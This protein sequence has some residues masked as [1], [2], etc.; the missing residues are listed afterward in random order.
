VAGEDRSDQGIRGDATLKETLRLTTDTRGQN[1]Q[2]IDFKAR[3]RVGPYRPWFFFLFVLLV[4]ASCAT[5]P[6]AP[7]PMEDAAGD[8]ALLPPGARAYL[9]ADVKEGR[10]LLEALSLGGYSARDA[11]QMLDRTGT[12]A[13]AFFGAPEGGSPAGGAGQRFFLVGRGDYPAIRAGISMTFSSGWKKIKSPTGNR[14]WHAPASG[15]ALALG[16][17]LA[18]VSTG[19]PFAPEKIPP[20]AIP[21]EFPLFRRPLAVAGWVP[22]PR[23]PVNNFLSSQGIPLQIPAEEL[24]FGAAR[25]GEDRDKWELVFRIRTASVNHAKALAALFGM[26]RN[27]I[28]GGAVPEAV[29]PLFINIPVQDGTVLTLRSGPMDE[30]QI[31]LLFNAFSVYSISK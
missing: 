6:K 22:N 14:Y 23:E 11:A 15:L 1:R 17:E 20:E 5:S 8:L 24:F 16:P 21:G 25:A 26:A 3:V 18:L 31:A 9:W 27:F 2:N 30:K 4:F 28:S 12:A 13:A 29:R 19:D 7:E 10:T